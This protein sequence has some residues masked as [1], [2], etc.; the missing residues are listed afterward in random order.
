M[1][2]T[3]TTP[4]TPRFCEFCGAELK[5]KPLELFG[6]RVIERVIPCSCKGSIEAIQEAK[7]IENNQKQLEAQ[8]RWERDLRRAG[9]RQRYWGEC[10]NEGEVSSVYDDAL[11]SGLYI[12]GEQGRGKT[13]LA[14]EIGKR[15]LR[16]KQKVVFANVPSLMRDIR[17]SYSS[18][19]VSS[20]EI[21]QKCIKARLLI[22]DDLGQ[23]NATKDTVEIIYEIVNE[24]D[25]D[26][27]PMVVT[28]NLRRDKFIPHYSK[29]LGNDEAA[30]NKAKSI[31]S[32]LSSLRSYEVKGSDHRIAR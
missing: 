29:Q 23:E 11:S 14:C 21:V 5:T 18:N 20:E 8:K 6:G 3:P 25:L 12:W 27:S 13:T 26:M 1:T 9:I 32:R 24:R 22:L 10:L 17:N 30:I 31:V 28:S 19:E 7:R 16:E 4:N 2:T 15:A